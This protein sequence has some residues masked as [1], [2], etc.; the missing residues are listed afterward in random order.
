MF[1]SEKKMDTYHS[2][3]LH[4]ARTSLSFHRSS[5]TTVVHRL[6]SIGH[7]H[8]DHRSSSDSFTIE[9]QQTISIAERTMIETYER[10]YLQELNNF[11]RLSSIY[12]SYLL[13]HYLV[14]RDQ[15]LLQ[16]MGRKRQQRRQGER[17]RTKTKSKSK[18]RKN[19]NR[20]HNHRRR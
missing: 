13:L 12:N 5:D 8:H 15:N 10:K 11:E 14:C 1:A 7:H 16:R 20:K 2:S 4:D 17:G 6:D 3:E 18:H 19:R 9:L